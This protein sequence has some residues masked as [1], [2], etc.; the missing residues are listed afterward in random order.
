MLARAKT[1]WY[2]IGAFVV[3]ATACS[4]AMT[5]AAIQVF[6]WHDDKFRDAPGSAIQV[7][8]VDIGISLLIASLVFA[9]VVALRIR[10]E[11]GGPLWLVV[12]FGAIYPVGYLMLG[13]VLI[14]MDPESIA[15]VV[16]SLAY[17]VLYPTL[18]AFGIRRTPI[19]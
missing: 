17:L 19:I 16:L 1:V 12:V 5:I 3:S 9:L 18:S 15:V 4:I 7:G 8:L 13:R 2:L 14:R 6:G 11:R 10:N